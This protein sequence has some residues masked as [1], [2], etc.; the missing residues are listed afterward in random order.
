MSAKMVQNRFLNRL[1]V[2]AMGG[3]RARLSAPLHYVTSKGEMIVVPRG[4]ET[5]YASTPPLARFGAIF[6]LTFQYLSRFH[7]FLYVLEA[8]ALWVCFV[9]EW[10]ENRDSDEAACVHDYLYATRNKFRWQADWILFEALEA[11]G[12]PLNPPWKR[13]LF[14]VNVRLFGFIPW[15]Q[16][17]RKGKPNA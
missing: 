16:D 2:E 17:A 12:A 11:Q 7:P 1:H 15:I 8:F 6:A 4:F 10:L 5:D 13:L 14:Y 9:A 3:S